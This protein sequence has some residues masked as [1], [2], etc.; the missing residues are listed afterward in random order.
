MDFNRQITFIIWIYIEC[1]PND[2]FRNEYPILRHKMRFRYLCSGHFSIFLFN[3]CHILHSQSLALFVGVSVERWW[4]NANIGRT[5]ENCLVGFYDMTFEVAKLSIRPIEIKF[6]RRKYHI[7]SFSIYFLVVVH[8]PFLPRGTHFSHTE[9]IPKSPSNKHTNWKILN[10]HSLFLSHNKTQSLYEL[11]TVW[12]NNRPIG[13]IKKSK[14]R[15]FKSNELRKKS[16]TQAPQ[17]TRWT[18]PL[19]YLDLR[20]SHLTYECNKKNAWNTL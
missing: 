10:T 15:P 16:Y 2:L 11:E 5:F 18:W 20:Q 3:S 17:H 8:T 19:S 13:M 14:S 4:A 6:Y 1:L 12:S 9:N 7:L